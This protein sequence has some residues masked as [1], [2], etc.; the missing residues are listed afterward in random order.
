[1]MSKLTCKMCILINDLGN[2][3]ACLKHQTLHNIN[4]SIEHKL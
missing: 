3:G 4:E 1:M 2:Q